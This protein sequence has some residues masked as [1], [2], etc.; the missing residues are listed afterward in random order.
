[1]QNREIVRKRIAAWLDSR[2]HAKV[3]VI[4]APAGSG[5]TVIAKQYASS[6]KP[7][8]LYARVPKGAGR[9][10]LREL[11]SA[12]GRRGVILDDVDTMEPSAYAT[13]VEDLCQGNVDAPLLLVGR[14]RR[15][16]LV[17]AL[18]ARGVAAVYESNGLA[19]EASEIAELA[20][21]FGVQH[22]DG[23]VSQLLYD[24]EGWALAVAWML[25][26]AAEDEIPL[27]DAYGAWCER[28]GS[29]LLDFVTNEYRGDLEAL[30]AFRAV[31]EGGPNEERARPD[32]LEHLEQDG[33]P[34]VRTRA[35][36]RPYRIIRRL[37]AAVRGMPS[38]RISQALPPIMLLSVL[39]EFRCRI[40]GRPVTFSRRRD[41]NVFAFVAITS[42]GRAR[43][44]AVLEAFWPRTDRHVAAQGLRTTISRIRR[45]IAEAA[46]GFDPDIYFKTEGDL[47]V[48]WGTVVVDA[49]RFHDLV[50]QGRLDETLGA[51][52]D[53]KR[54]YRLAYGIYRGRLLASEPLEPCFERPANAF[55][56]LYVEALGRLTQLHAATGHLDLAR[57]YAREYLAY[58]GEGA[59]TLKTLVS[60]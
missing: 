49:R 55:D 3:R 7:G 54:H 37:T 43:R 60:G 14:S 47:C 21:K 31:L 11:V 35:G 28:N 52:D 15:R 38:D 4:A 24:T 32:R 39:G 18:L 57:E 48:D 23:D 12:G 27:R 34:L 51:L 1:M 42:G 56:R 10:V 25:R 45:A 46:P 6:R 44:E 53:A 59:S 41:Q 8:M 13:F 29:L 5:K 50:E 19:F 26:E 40:G 17:H 20:C 30:D 36:A 9:A 2:S 22:S 16:L 33:F 58:S